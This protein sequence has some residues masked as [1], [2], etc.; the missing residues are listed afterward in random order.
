MPAPEPSPLSTYLAH[1]ERGQLAYQFS[2]QAGRA[3]F[4]PRLLCPFTGS[5]QLEW[6]VSKG[7]GTVYSTTVVNPHEGAPYNVAL[8]DCDEGFRLMSR[9][10]GIA[11]EAVRIGMRVQFRAHRP[12]GEEAPMPIFHVVEA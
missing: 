3:V 1:L 9:V 2:P 12:A 8:I 10:E 5:D 6:R 7:F 4:Y 11:P